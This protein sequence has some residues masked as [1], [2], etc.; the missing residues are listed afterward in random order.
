MSIDPDPPGVSEPLPAIE[1]EIPSY[2]AI[3]P[4]AVASLVFGVLSV[5]CVAG[6][7]FLVFPILAV[8][9]GTLAQRKIQRMP[10]LF[11]GKGFAQA[12][13]ALGLVCGISS[14]TYTT[15]QHWMLTRSAERYI[16]HYADILQKGGLSDAYWEHVHFEA[17][18]SSSPK[19]ALEGLLKQESSEP[20]M[21]MDSPLTSLKTIQQRVEKPGAHPIHFLDIEQ[22][23]FDGRTPYAYGVV[24]V[25]A[26][27]AGQPEEFALVG[28]RGDPNASAYRWM[29]SSLQ[30]PY[31]RKS[32]VMKP[33][34]VDDG[35]GH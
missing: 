11:T 9:T 32:F 13:V 33:K 25:P 27:V 10:D 14:I 4:M 28:L 6:L 15:I 35:H 34:P 30:F 18:K 22:T 5:L 7:S 31:Q 2:R 17:R 21:A 23:G 19:Q 24:E 1:N 20:A 3:T 16:K 8:I 26:E 12:G 29:V